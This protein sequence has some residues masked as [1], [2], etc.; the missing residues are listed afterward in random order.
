MIRY[1]D[2]KVIEPSRPSFKS[3]R[4]FSVSMQKIYTKN[5]QKA[6]V[7]NL[8]NSTEH[9]TGKGQHYL[10]KGHL[11][12]DADFVLEPE[13]DATYYYANAIPQWQGVNNGNWKVICTSTFVLYKTLSAT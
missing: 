12:P 2:A 5:M 11:S 9:L 8:L 10:A 1:I 13:Q 4:M 6:L 3:A 7:T